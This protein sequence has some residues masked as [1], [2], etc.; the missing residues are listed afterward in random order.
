MEKISKFQIAKAGHRPQEHLFVVNSIIALYQLLDIPLLLQ[1]F[2]IVKFF[3]KESLRDGMF[4][5]NKAGIRGKIYR[6]WSKLNE[7]TKIRV[8]TGMGPTE[9]EEVG[10]VLGQGSHAG[11]IIS[12]ANLDDGVSAA[13]ENS[14]DE[15]IYGAVRLNPLLFQDDILKMSVSTTGAQNAL[16]RIESV[17]T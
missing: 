8:I 12:A 16:N 10:E 11:A 3:D 6:L 17:R 4:V 13:F 2:D 14:T 1:F 9:Y 5:V 15:V 7:K